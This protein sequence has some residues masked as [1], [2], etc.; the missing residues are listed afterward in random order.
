MKFRSIHLASCLAVAVAAT[1]AHAQRDLPPFE[2]V[3]KDYRKV[4]STADGSQSLWTIYRNNKDNQL[5]AELPN[6]FER[7]RIF[8]ATSISGGNE[9]TGWQW[10]DSYVYWKKINDRL[11]LMEPELMYRAKGSRE[12]ESSVERTYSDRVILS[13]PIITNGPNGGP[14]FD[15]DRLLVGESSRFAMP[16]DPSLTIIESCKAFP[17]NLEISFEGP[18]SNGRLTRIHY[19]MSVIPRTDYQPREADPRIGYFLTVY[20]DFNKSSHD[21]NQF[22][23]Y[24]NRWNVKKRD[25]SLKLSPPERP[26]IFYLEHTI[27][28]KYRRYVRDGI[29]E[30]NKAFEK[31]GIDGAIEVRQQD[32]MT[33]AYMDH[34]PEDVRYNFIRWI[35]SERAFAMG[36]SRV[37]PETG[38]ILDADIIFDDSMIRYYILDYQRQIAQLP[39]EDATPETLAFLADNP[40]WDP[41]TYVNDSN[42]AEVVIR[43]MDTLSDAEKQRL[44]AHAEHDDA[45][46]LPDNVLTRVVQGNHYCNLAEGVAHR[47]QMARLAFDS[48]AYGGYSDEE[49]FDGLPEKFI[50]QILA[51]IVAHEVGHTLGL[52]HNFKASSWKSLEEM[53]AQVGEPQVGSVMDYNP[54]NIAP[55]GVDQGDWITPTIGPYDYW[56]IEYGYTQDDKA[57]PEIVQRSA[58][59]A[60]VYATDEDAMGPDPLVMRFD[61]GSDPLDYCARQVALVHQLRS[62][63]LDRAVKD[64]ESYHNARS[65]FRSLLYEQAWTARTAARFVGGTYINRDHRGTPNARPPIVPVEADR[66]RKALEFVIANAFND[67]AFGLDPELLQY[68]ATDKFIHWGNFS[69][70]GQPEYPVHNEIM[71]IQRGVLLSVMNPSTMRRIYDNEFMVPADEDAFTVPELL[72]SLTASIWTEVLS[73]PNRSQ[74]FSNREPM[75]SSLRRNLQREYLA[76]LGDLATLSGSYG[77]PRA[78]QGIS[79]EWLNKLNDSIGM[80]L[81]EGEVDNLDDYTRTHLQECQTDI[82]RTLEAVAVY[83]GN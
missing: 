62:E 8:V 48:V 3:A 74:N 79:L 59:P 38:E 9:Y 19:S 70:Y 49:L 28:V 4:V 71:Q 64:G 5:L 39:V 6:G 42:Y 50:G 13:V 68:L 37:N 12:I 47:L 17:E 10:G 44:L 2:E 45:S 61:A 24:I 83:N 40:R 23:R 43:N 60:L 55:E 11:V 58:E 41:R 31:I 57:L 81:E 56:A 34:D 20:K 66:Q 82:T 1:S 63:L 32:S 80:H 54:I 35:T 52:R 51:E 26:I 7:Q 30:W 27:P 77:F 65:F 69:E 72:N 33:G 29:L 76:N 78:V 22:V 14:V 73:R 36:P 25:A 75:I 46:S 67:E 15:L 53:N 16:L 18:G 21:G